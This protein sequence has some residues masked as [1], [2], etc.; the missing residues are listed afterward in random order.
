MR[1]GPNWWERVRIHERGSELMGEGPNWWERF[2]LNERGS[3]FMREDPNCWERFQLHGRVF[4][5]I[6]EGPDWWEWVRIDGRD[7]SFMGEVPTWWQSDQTDGEGSKLMTEILNCWEVW[8]GE[9]APILIGKDSTVPPKSVLSENVTSDRECPI[10]AV[11]EISEPTFQ[12]LTE[13]RRVPNNCDSHFMCSSPN[14]R[15]IKSRRINANFNWE[16]CFDCIT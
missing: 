3:D 9:R 11:R 6:T 8:P 14:S 2:Q 4:D 12:D 1:E 7:S 5:L 16:I 15:K 10:N 13:S